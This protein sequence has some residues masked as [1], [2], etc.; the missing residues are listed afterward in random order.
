[1]QVWGSRLACRGLVVGISPAPNRTIIDVPH[2][3]TSEMLGTFFTTVPVE[4]DTSAPQ[5]SFSTLAAAIASRR[6]LCA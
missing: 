2:I 6:E 3:H 5:T 4:T 1:M